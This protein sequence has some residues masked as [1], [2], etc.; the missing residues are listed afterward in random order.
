ME[1]PARSGLQPVTP[2]LPLPHQVCPSPGC[3]EQARSRGRL[4]HGRCARRA[5]A[6]HPTS[7]TCRGLGPQST[8]QGPATYLPSEFG[9]DRPAVEGKVQGTHQGLED[10]GPWEELLTVLTLG[11]DSEHRVSSQGSLQGGC[12]LSCV[13]GRGRGPGRLGSQP[14]LQDK[15]G[16]ERRP[17]ST[18]ALLLLTGPQ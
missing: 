4:A 5:G 15:K 2:C 10:K 9:G 18:S 3:S 13:Q 1:P 14:M 6:P 11:S 7:L 12:H 16:F 17:I 8:G